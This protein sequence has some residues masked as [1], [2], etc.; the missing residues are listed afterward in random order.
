VRPLV[1]SA[2]QGAKVTCF[3]YG[4]T[5]SGK[6]YTM[7]GNMSQGLPGLYTLGANDIFDYLA[8]VHYPN[9]AS[10]PTFKSQALILL[11]LLWQT[12]RSFK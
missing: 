3:A 9:S 6:T 12:I 11:N 5:G 4:Q 8:S 1:D 7:N 10:I 2:F